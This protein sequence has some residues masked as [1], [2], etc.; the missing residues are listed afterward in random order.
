MKKIGIKISMCALLLAPF[1]PQFAMNVSAQESSQLQSTQDIVN[2][3][4]A[5]FKGYLNTVLGQPS[6]HD[7]T[8]AQMDT[9]KN[10]N[11]SDSKLVDLTGIEYA[12]N[13]E[14]VL[15]SNTGVTDYTSLETLTN[16]IYINLSGDN[17]TPEALP[18]FNNLQK[19]T[20]L[21]LSN[22]KLDNT[23][24]PKINHIPNLTNLNLDK[25]FSITD[26]SSLQSLPNLNTLFVQFCGIHDFQGIEAFP[27]LTNLAAY[28]QNIGRT[29][30]INSSIKS[31]VLNYNETDQTFFV[32]FSLMKD[33]LTNFNGDVIPFTT[34]TSSSKTFFTLNEQKID[35]SRLKID[36]KGITV[37]GI[38]REYFNSIT[39]MEYNSAYE[40]PA[41]SYV[42]PSN[43]PSYSISNG[44]YDH[45]FDIDHSLT[46]SSDPTINY[47]ENTVI[48]EEQFLNDIHAETD[49]GTTITSN[50]KSVVDFQKPGVYEVT[51]NAENE[52]GIKAAPRQVSITILEK[53][54]ITALNSISY[55]EGTVLTEEQFL[56]DISA[57]T[58]SPSEI[59]SDF[60]DVVKLDA[61]G[62][63]E[64][65]L[66]ATSEAG[67]EADPVKVQ[68]EIQEKETNTP[69]PD[70][71]SSTIPDSQTIKENK[72]SNVK[73]SA[74]T[75]SAKIETPQKETIKTPET[76]IT[77]KEATATKINSNNKE[78]KTVEVHTKTTKKEL[79]KTGDTNQPTNV[80]VGI[81]LAGLA[82]I[83]FR[84][85]KQH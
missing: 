57:A 36:D 25:N 1:S 71:E 83:F 5:V 31:S 8:E 60:E 26:I 30:L 12:H 76:K 63:Y 67:V 41:G 74:P 81:A 53:P 6:S 18:N 56:K 54:V 59:T 28:G 47:P 10:I 15:L 4:D 22:S 21:T 55:K 50:F 66:Y 69:S 80:L 35:G 11:I 23:I 61:L 77:E 33:R 84:N 85:R 13:L 78:N 64:V 2:I 7:I 44:T 52:A 45:Y 58:V 46:I 32:P 75:D 65:T 42:S 49:D 24:F 9:I 3:P 40:S 37:S 70:K 14:S 17:V 34:S 82:I 19:L 72:K 39:K 43:I 38:T 27:K 51:L 68:V 79:P 16:L 29:E 62:T 20:N 48:T 73:E